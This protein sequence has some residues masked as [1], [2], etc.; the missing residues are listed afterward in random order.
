MKV[1]IAEKPSV[2]GEIAKII[3]ATQRKDGY[4]EGNGF[5]VTWTFGHLCTL[6]EPGDYNPYY[7]K[8]DIYSLP[9]SPEKFEIKV[10]NDN[11]VKT[12][13]GRIKNLVQNATEVINCGDAG[14]EGE[15]I[16][17]WVLEHAEC[18]APIKRLW[19]SSLTEEAIREGFNKL[20]PGTDFDPLF[21]AGRSRAISDWL[22]GINATRLYTMKYGKN[23]QVLSVGRV[24]TPTLAMIVKRHFEIKNFVPGIYFEIKTDYNNAT[25]SYEKGK[26]DEKTKAD[27]LMIQ[28]REHPL[29]ITDIKIKEGKE[30]PPNLFDLTSLQIESNKKLGLTAEQTLNTLQS[31]YEKK[32]VT[33]PRVDTVFLPNDQYPKIKGIMQGLTMY[34]DLVSPLLQRAIKKSNKVFNDKKITD[35]H[36]II[37]TGMKANNIA[38]P[39]AAIYDLITRRFISA[40]YPEC[41]VS[42]TTIKAKVDK[43][44]FRA[45]G[46]QILHPGWRIVYQSEKRAASEDKI[47]P[48]FEKGESG[49]HS[50]RLDLKKTSA[51]KEY[52][53]ATLLRA[54]ETAGRDVADEEMKQLM[55]ENGIGRP[56]T[57]ANIIETLFRRKYI[58][59][60]KKSMRA[61]DVGIKLIQLIENPTLKSARLTGQWEK[62]MRDIENGNYSADEFIGGMRSLVEDL[63]KEVVASNPSI[64]KLHCPKCEVGSIVKG[65]S[66][67]GCTEWINGCSFQIPFE[68]NGMQIDGSLASKLITQRKVIFSPAKNGT[69]TVAYLKEDFTTEIRAEKPLNIKCPKCNAGSMRKG[70]TAYGC[71]EFKKTCDFLI[72]FSLLPEE[73]SNK[74]IVKF[75]T[76]KQIQTTKRIL[77]LTHDFGI[78]TS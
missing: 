25:F 3:G 35:H 63:V 37:P 38:G 42:N 65:K 41:R 4:Y 75:L 44:N 66:A 11:G 59:K 1:C 50:P 54:M 51:P 10:I 53:E 40:F 14:Q 57:R 71:S 30:H 22:Y 46:K 21:N 17:R 58:E 29:T 5:Q 62:K 61:T 33:Y 12:Q 67:F 69:A 34:Q 43:H 48:N 31:L 73:T 2:A 74:Q 28:M 55:K 15:L 52:T 7:K 6:N 78:E 19:I 16:Q 27:A 56:S 72:P 47:L 70:S 18:K 26:I 23:K 13:F 68:S 49:P 60:N 24:Q 45:T 36:A 8:W 39:E 20:M 77:K 76:E 64:A 32:L 9:I